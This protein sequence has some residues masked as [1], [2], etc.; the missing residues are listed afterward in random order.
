MILIRSVLGAILAITTVQASPHN[1]FGVRSSNLGTRALATHNCADFGT[2]APNGYHSFGDV[3]VD[4]DTTN[5]KVT[6]PTLPAGNMYTPPPTGGV[7]LYLGCQAPTDR[8][9]GH[10]PYNSYCTWSGTSASCTVPLSVL[11]P[12]AFSCG[13][14]G[15]NTH[16]FVA[17][18]ADVSGPFA[19]T[20]WGNIGGGTI[21]DCSNP[22]GNCAKYWDFYTHCEC[23]VVTTFEP[24]SCTSTITSITV[25]VETPPPITSGS[26]SCNDPST[27]STVIVDGGS[28]GACSPCTVPYFCGCP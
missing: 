9:P 1:S 28:G 15:C 7:H 27:T 13:P 8:Q 19:G 2:G 25:I 5:V 18:H 12:P 17:A 26:T 4:I 14:I 3:C 21:F 16:L 24:V 10:F 11:T 20:G 23:P 22:N 6:F